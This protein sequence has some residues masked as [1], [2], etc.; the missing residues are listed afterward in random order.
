MYIRAWN[1]YQ[2]A[3]SNNTSP[4]WIQLFIVKQFRKEYFGN[5]L[6]IHLVPILFGSVNC[7]LSFTFSFLSH[8][9][10]LRE[11]ITSLVMSVCLSICLSDCPSVRPYIWNN[12]PHTR[13]IFMEFVIFRK[14]AQKIEVSLKSDKSNR[15][16]TWRP[17]YIY[18]NI[19][20]NYS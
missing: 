14:S 7:V 11:A 15:Y 12:K 9:A 1:V 13:R 2:K 3:C 6:H 10:Q 17:I 20:F 19:S 4:S 18:D 16:F 8:F 5:I